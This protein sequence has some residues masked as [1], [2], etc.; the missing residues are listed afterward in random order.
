[1]KKKKGGKSDQTPASNCTANLLGNKGHLKKNCKGE[2]RGTS[3]KPTTA[4]KLPQGRERLPFKYENTE[5]IFLQGK[6]YY[7]EGSEKNGNSMW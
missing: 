2:K 1:M 6:Y 5:E 3:G 7:R 4:L